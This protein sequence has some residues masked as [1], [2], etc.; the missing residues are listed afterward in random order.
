[1]Y[2]TSSNRLRQDA[3]RDGPHGQRR[4]IRA[5]GGSDAIER[6]RL[7]G[8]QSG[9]RPPAG[10]CSTRLRALAH[11]RCRARGQRRQDLSEVDRAKSVH[12]RAASSGASGFDVAL[13]GPNVDATRG[14]PRKPVNELMSAVSP[15]TAVG[16]VL[17][18]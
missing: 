5:V 4:R 16:F 15:S 10:P 11:A 14:R 3:P 13:T 12:V 2:V 1:M 9:R 7:A 8:A 17:A 6:G 18:L